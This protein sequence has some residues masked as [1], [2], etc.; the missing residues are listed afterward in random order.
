[1]MKSVYA[2]IATTLNLSADKVQAAFEQAQS[3]LKQ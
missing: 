2:S 3:E 1:M